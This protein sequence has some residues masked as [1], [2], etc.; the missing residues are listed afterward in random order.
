VN[1]FW[2]LTRYEGRTQLLI[3]NPINRY[4]INSPM[5]PQLKKNADGSL[6]IYVQK[7]SPGKDKDSNW[8]PAPDGPMFTV[9]RLYWPRTEPPSVPPLGKGTWKPPGVVPPSNLRA[10]DVT[11]V[12]DK[13]LENFIRTDERYG[14]D[15]LFQGPRGWGTGMTSSTPGRSRTRT[16]GPT[17]SPPTSSAA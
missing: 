5:L 8:L 4:L 2:S 14:H 1:A 6:T 10:Q 7:D 11:R 17:R 13:S 16:C 12:G 9:M 15:G 3:E